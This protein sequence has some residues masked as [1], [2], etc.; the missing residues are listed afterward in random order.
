V[1]N[2]PVQPWGIQAPRQALNINEFI[3]QTIGNPQ[4]ESV[5]TQLPVAPK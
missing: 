1:P 2:A 5:T 4:W 3:A